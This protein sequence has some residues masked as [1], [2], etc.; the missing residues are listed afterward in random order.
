MNTIWKYP[1]QLGFNKLILP[2]GAIVL[3]CQPQGGHITLWVLH[4][5]DQVE[6]VRYF[7]VHG[8]GHEL[9]EDPGMHVGTV[10]M[11]SFVWHV[12]EV[13]DRP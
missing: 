4:D 3:E 7:N 9:D 11:D 1:I 13:E 6:V 10:Q 5:T 12:F 2:K 8:T